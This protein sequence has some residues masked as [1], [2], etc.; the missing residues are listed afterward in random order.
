MSSLLSSSLSPSPNF[1]VDQTLNVV[2]LDERSFA[3]GRSLARVAF[4]QVRCEY[5]LVIGG[6][7]I[8]NH[9]LSMIGQFA[10]LVDQLDRPARFVG[11]FRVQFVQKIVLDRVRLFHHTAVLALLIAATGA[12]SSVLIAKDLAQPIQAVAADL[13]DER[14]VAGVHV[15]LVQLSGQ[16]RVQLL[17][18]SGQPLL[19]CGRRFVLQNVRIAQSAVATATTGRRWSRHIADRRYGAIQL[20]VRP[21]VVQAV[22]RGRVAT[23]VVALVAD[24]AAVDDGGD[25]RAGA[26]ARRIGVHGGGG[27]NAFV[28]LHATIQEVELGARRNERRLVGGELAG[29]QRRSHDRLV[30]RVARRG[31]LRGELGHLAREHLLVGQTAA[32]HLHDIAERWSFVRRRLQAP[33]Q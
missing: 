27:R 25:G 9:R 19:V 16:L 29:V 13:L 2:R 6:W 33:L 7:F 22:Q 26:G 21:C 23:A 8:C 18:L 4:K 28:A 3:T 10:R 5:E 17:V 14:S 32:E 20:A 31:R 1:A 11:R 24:V 12:L 30:R 15:Q